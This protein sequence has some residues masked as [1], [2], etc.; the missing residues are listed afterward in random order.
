MDLIQGLEKPNLMLAKISSTKDSEARLH[1]FILDRLKELGWDTRSCRRGGS[2]YAQTELRQNP[3]LKQALGF[4][5]PEYIVHLN[6]NEF[7]VIEAKSDVRDLKVAVNEAEE[8]ANKINQRSK[9][10]CRIITGISGSPDSTY[11]V[12]TRC[13]VGN[14]WNVLSINNRTATG[15]LS[16]IQVQ[17]SLDHGKIFD[18]E[19]DDQLFI[20]RTQSI[21]KILHDGAINKRNRAGTLAC[22]LL[23]LAEEQTFKLSDNTS[24]L[25]KDI[26]TRAESLLEKYNKKNFFDQIKIS[27]PPSK[28]NHEKHRKSI[29]NVI[30][31]LRDLNI[32]STINSGRDVLGQFYEQFL[33]YANDAKEIGIVLT[34]RHITKWGVELVSVKEDDVVFDPACGTGGFLVSALDF[35]RRE[36]G[37]GVNSIPVIFTALNRIPWWQ[38]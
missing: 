20:R 30:E 18:Y 35:V 34:P 12:E 17:Q 4:D 26:N 10:S 29:S 6:Q 25:I 36:G 5:H 31:I 11:L 9:L 33:K 16:P 23:A 1:G 13:K 19:I 38:H 21:N 2:V 24:T 7:W 32:A 28:E 15:F 22:I 37:G 8:Y 14:Q 27:L 3:Q